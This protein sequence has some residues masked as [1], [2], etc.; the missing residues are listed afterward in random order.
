MIMTI[1]KNLFRRLPLAFLVLCL[2]ASAQKFE[3][4]G[5][6]T[7]IS[8]DQGLDGFTVGTAVWFTHR[9]SIAA[10]YDGVW[11]TSKIGQF[12]LTQ[13]GLII[14]KSHLQDYLFGPRISFPGLIKSKEKHVAHLLPFGEAQFGI[15]HLNSTLEDATTNVSQSSSS[16]AFSWMLGGGADYRFSPHWVGRLRLDLLRTHLADAGQSRVRLGAGVAYT[17]GKR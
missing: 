16:S 13:T 2:T 12:E 6:A 5:G 11:D 15:S 4:N 9:V 7:H 10:D 8:G 1:V 14:S 17:F 3:L